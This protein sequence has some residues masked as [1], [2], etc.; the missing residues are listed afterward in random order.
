MKTIIHWAGE[1]SSHVATIHIG[2]FRLAALLSFV[3]LPFLSAHAQFA[4]ATNNGQITITKY[5]GSAGNV[6]IPSVLHG[7]PVTAIGKMA[8]DLDTRILS[9]TIPDSVVEI[10]EQAFWCCPSLTN[11]SIGNGVTT[12]GDSAF[13]GCSN[14]VTVRVGTNVAAIGRNAFR[15]CTR[16]SDLQLPASLATVGFGAF[17]GCSMLTNITVNPGCDH[18]SSVDGVLFNGDQTTL[19][20]FPPGRSGK[21]STPGSVTRIT[22]YAF[23]QCANLTAVSLAQNVTNLGSSAFAGCSS[24][25]EVNLPESLVGIGLDGFNSCGKL[26]KLTL[27][28]GLIDVGSRAFAGCSNLTHIQI[29]PSVTTIGWDVFADCTELGSITIGKGVLAIG[30]PTFSR[31]TNLVEISVDTENPTYSSDAGVLFN[32]QKTELLCCP[33]GKA[34]YY[35]IPQT[36]N[37][38]GYAAFSYCVHLTGVSIPAT[39]SAIGGRA[40]EGCTQLAS[41]TIPQGV[42]SIAGAVF[43]RCTNLASVIIPS[44]VTSIGVGA[45]EGCT[46]LRSVTIPG[47]VTSLWCSAFMGCANLAGAYF[48]G[49]APPDAADDAFCCAQ[50]TIVYYLP[51]TKGWGPTFAGRPTAVWNPRLQVDLAAGL[52]A[53]NGL[54][55]S[56]HGT[57]NLTVVVEAS[58]DL[59]SPAWHAIST[60]TLTGGS[61]RLIDALWTNY[62]TRF[63]RLR[64]P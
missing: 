4:C 48:T 55:F 9:V 6:V 45:F 38:I 26:A 63:Y 12:V 1:A 44:S 5:N 25:A 7:F 13:L 47:S 49:D 62:S 34:G 57:S 37:T 16:L 54:G 35:A 53:T 60:N 33:G 30:T 32:R 19:L 28:N 15:A 8:F 46:A 29:P 43:A 50:P 39:A 20:V 40:F 36:V 31:C 56:I 3:F 17:T 58:T 22:D 41:V 59:A 14:L 2:L 11:V 61:A 24:L 23:Y 51:G 18:Y 27:N 52:I 42:S 64:S 21:Y 10:G